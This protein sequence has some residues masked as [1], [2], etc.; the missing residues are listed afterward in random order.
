MRN[1]QFSSPETDR[2]IFAVLRKPLL[3]FVLLSSLA[4]VGF[5]LPKPLEIP[6]IEFIDTLFI[7]ALGVFVWGVFH[8][9]DPWRDN[10]RW[11]LIRTISIPIVWLL[12]VLMLAA[13]FDH[14]QPM[15]RV[16]EIQQNIL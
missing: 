9:F 14:L 12:L 10:R 16:E 8:L 2:K 5:L 13:W 6:G 7:V 1:I 3:I 15:V 11:E 4:T